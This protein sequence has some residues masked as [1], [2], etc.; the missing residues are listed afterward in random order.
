MSIS[1]VPGAARRPGGAAHG[2]PGGG[3]A[4]SPVTLAVAGLGGGLVVDVEVVGGAGVLARRLRR[5]IPRR[6]ALARA[7]GARVGG[8]MEVL[9]VGRKVVDP[10]IVR[11]DEKGR[12]E[13]P[14]RR[15]SPGSGKADVMGR[16]PAAELDTT[17][18]LEP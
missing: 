4:A 8:V 12:L 10:S 15:R 2:A 13:A 3:N 11:H 6:R 7:P 17:G 1:E 14:R 5:V 18:A 9:S 16:R